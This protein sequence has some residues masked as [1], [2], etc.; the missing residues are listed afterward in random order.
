M[1]GTPPRVPG[2]YAEEMY[3]SLRQDIK[4]LS[5]N[6]SVN[7][8]IPE[9]ERDLEKTR[10][11]K[12][13]TDT[14]PTW[15]REYL[16]KVGSYDTEALV[17]RFT[18]ANHYTESQLATWING[19]PITDIF[20]SGGVDYGFDDQDS[21]VIH[22]ASEHKG[23]RFVLYEYKGN[24]TG[25]TDFADKM[26]LGIARIAKD[27]LLAKVNKQFTWYCDTEGLGKKITFELAQQF[28]L[29]VSPAYQGQPEIMVEMMQ[30][31][32]RTGRF[33]VHAPQTIDGKEVVSIMEEEARK[34]VFARDE[35]DRLT[36]RIDDEVF[37]P[38]AMKSNLY[39]LRYIWLRSKVKMGA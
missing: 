3:L 11:E 38:E 6:L 33:K 13:F 22:L 2:N 36:R 28:G 26:K 24:R 8:H 25:I 10:I 14:D 18:P 37:H 12:G 31:D 9:S 4:R 39:S 30:D 1:G 19:Q 17:L 34:I 32:V 16:G 29:S 5:W 7:P 23:E 27:P 35:Q 20:L 21:C 15:Q